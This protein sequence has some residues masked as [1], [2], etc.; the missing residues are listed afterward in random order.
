MVTALSPV[1]MVTV[2]LFKSSSVAETAL[3]TVVELLFFV[4][5]V[6]EELRHMDLVSKPTQEQIMLSCCRV[7]NFIRMSHE[8]FVELI[9]QAME[10]Y[11]YDG[12]EVNH[13]DW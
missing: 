2:L 6:D 7:E 8:Q 4:D 9:R 12:N 11:G 1:P 5:F 10:K 3:S 13:E